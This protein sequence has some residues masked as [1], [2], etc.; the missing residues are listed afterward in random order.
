MKPSRAER[1]ATFRK[2]DQ[3]IA[4]QSKHI[5]DKDLGYVLPQPWEFLMSGGFI[6]QQIDT[7]PGLFR[8]K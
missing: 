2:V 1:K 4:A 6:V 5:R 3:Q 8:K 7:R